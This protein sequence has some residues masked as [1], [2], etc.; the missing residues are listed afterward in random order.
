VPSTFRVDIVNGIG[1]MMTAFIAANPTVIRRHFRRRPPSTNN[2]IPYSYLDLRPEAI[3]HVSGLRE[4]VLSPSVV[5]VFAIT[6][7]LET[8]DLQDAAT[9]LLIDHFTTYP[10][11]V[12]GTVWDAITVTE[13]NAPDGLTDRTAVR[14]TF[15]NIS[16]H[17]G[18]T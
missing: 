4:R 14:F 15:G 16:I 17:E 2:D 18:R 1:T 7:N 3:S 6:D 11:L 10:H 8:A 5:A 13:E 9:D 12:A